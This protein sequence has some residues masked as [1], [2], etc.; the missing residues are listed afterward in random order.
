MY[1]AWKGF[2]NSAR[3]DGAIFHHWE[4]STDKKDGNKTP[5]IFH[6]VSTIF[7]RLQIC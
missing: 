7:H 3:K 1:R 2:R 4:K 5:Q 6:Y